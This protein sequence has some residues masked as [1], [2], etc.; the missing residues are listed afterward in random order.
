[1]ATSNF[2]AERNEKSLVRLTKALPAIFPAA[3]LRRAL[4]RPFIPPTPRLAVEGYWRAHPLR[5]DRLARALAARTGTPE[6]WTWRLAPDRRTGGKRRRPADLERALPASFRMPPAPFREAKF[7]RGAGHCCVCGQPVYRLG[8]HVDLWGAGPNRKARWHAA[9]VVAWQ[10]WT[11]P[12]DQVALLKKRQAR[13]CARTGARLWRTAEV[14][15][16]LPLFRVWTEHR[17]LAWPA[18]LAF[19]GAP[20]LQVINRDTHVEKCAAEAGYRKQRRTAAASA[21]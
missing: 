4:G 18:L 17:D 2:R 20:N 7:A 14:D 6:G 19:W 1:M 21:A 10:L 11:A 12:S 15:H 13:R 5:A 9:C 3:V 16:R 8:W